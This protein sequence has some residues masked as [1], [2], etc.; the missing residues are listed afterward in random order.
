MSDSTGAGEPPAAQG[1]IPTGQ[2]VQVGDRNTQK[3]Q[4]IQNYIEQQQVIQPPQAPTTGPVVAGEVPQPSP[5]FQPRPELLDALRESG[6]AVAVVRAVTGMPGVGKTQVAAAYARACIDEGWRLVAWI[7]AGNTTQVLN[8]LALVAARLGIGDPDADPADVAALVRNRLE[9]DGERCLM[10]FDNLTDLDGVRP[11]LPAAGKA[12]VVITSTGQ[13]AA[14][15]GRPMPVDVFSEEQALVFLA[16]RTGRADPAGACELARELGYLPLALAQAAA[17]VAVQRL[18]YQRYLNRLRSLPVQE[19]LTPAAGDTY[20]HGVAQAVLLSLDA[21]ASADRTGLCTALICVV[22]LL[23]TAGVPR[24]LLYAAATTGVFHEEGKEHTAADPRK[25]EQDIDEA[26]GTLADASLLTFSGDGLTVSAHRLVMRAARELYAHD[27]ALATIG[28]RACD[29]LQAV[30]FSLTQPWQNRAAARDTIQQVTALNDHLSSHLGAD[31]GAVAAQLFFLRLWAFSCMSQLG[32]SPV[33][34]IEYGAPLLAECERGLGDTHR[35]TLT[36]RHRLATAYKDA[37]RPADAIPMLERSVADHRRVLGSTDP[38]TVTACHDLA[39]AY[40]DAELR[41]RA[42]VLLRCTLD[43]CKQVLGDNDP[44]TLTTHHN[45]ARAFQDSQWQGRAFA[46]Q[47]LE[48]SLADCER[49]LGN[50]DPETLGAR[51]N[52]AMAY[53]DAGKFDEAIQMLER[54]LGDVERLLGDTGLGALTM[55]HNLAITC[56]AAGRLDEA[57][58]M[59][60]RNVADHERVMGDT[61]PETIS[62]CHDLG[63]AY[64]A[65]GQLDRA[66]PL[67]ERT[68]ADRERTLGKTHTLSKASRSNLIHAY[69]KAGLDP[70]AKFSGDDLRQVR[71]VMTSLE[72]YYGSADIDRRRAP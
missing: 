43:E 32:D 27:G 41:Q 28:S 21:A 61:H 54:T 8:G 30:A 17:V 31:H 22:S 46:I 6:P 69:W 34:T 19:Y 52:L 23:S 3:N 56:K 47:M 37:G 2:G 26:L 13:G 24:E 53:R 62:T 70:L 9:A 35:F 55:R 36:A 67:Y 15:M 10:V 42:L 12:Q 71:A 65:A 45:L 48:R 5:A 29:L 68:L 16:Q 59:L 57:I 14:V 44:V 18:D 38:I 4:F 51:H 72:S 63:T 25:V 50:T 7:N 66:I 39:R 49:V 64:E 60:E 1:E 58:P 40:L 20:P 33:R 11:F